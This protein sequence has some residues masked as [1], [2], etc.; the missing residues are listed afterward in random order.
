MF[1]SAIVWLKAR[2]Y[3][4]LG[5]LTALAAAVVAV[6][7]SGKQAEKVDA[8]KANIK[9]IKKKVEVER[10]VDRIPDGDAAK[11]LRDSWSRD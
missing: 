6:R 10:E 5:A 1:F 8:M 4:I 11:R 2:A 7:Q 3:L 9:A